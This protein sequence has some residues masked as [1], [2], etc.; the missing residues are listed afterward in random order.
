MIMSLTITSKCSASFANYIQ[1]TCCVVESSSNY[2]MFGGQLML[3]QDLERSAWRNWTQQNSV[4]L[5]SDFYVNSFADKET[6]QAVY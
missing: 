2:S 4:E 6:Y 3:F 1:K 5:A